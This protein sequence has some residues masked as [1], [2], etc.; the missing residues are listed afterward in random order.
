MLLWELGASSDGR[1]S[2]DGSLPF[3]AYRLLDKIF[4]LNA[5]NDSSPLNSHANDVIFAIVNCLFLFQSDC[6]V[7]II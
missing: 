7:K 4:L 1:A 2:G 3:S 6:K 5:R